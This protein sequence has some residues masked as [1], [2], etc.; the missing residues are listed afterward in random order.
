MQRQSPT[1]APAQERGPTLKAIGR[2]CDM[3]ESGLLPER[4]APTIENKVG[5]R[6]YAATLGCGLAPA[7][8]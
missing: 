1:L 7:Q 4:A 6:R 5:F 8:G 3:Q 2:L